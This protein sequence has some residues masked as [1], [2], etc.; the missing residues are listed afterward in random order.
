MKKLLAVLA[1]F[2]LPACSINPPPAY[3]C[4]N[5]P[6][7]SGLVEVEEPMLAQYIVVLKPA[8][9]ALAAADLQSFAT[10][11]GGTNVQSLQRTINGFSAN[12]SEANLQAALSNPRV[13]YI[14][15]VGEKHI[16]AAEW[17]LDRIDQ[18]DL[19]LDGSYS[20]GAT[21]QGVN[22]AIVDTGVTDVPEFEGRLVLDDC[23]SAYGS[24]DDGHG[25]GTHVAGTVG[26][27]TY[28][29]AKKVK[30]WRAR[31]L[32]AQGSGSDAA[33]IGGIEWVTNKALEKGGRWV[34]NM[35][36]GGSAS[37]ALDAAVC[38]AIAA[39]V[40][41]AVAAGNETRDSRYSSPAR[42]LQAITAGASDR[43]DTVA[44]F[45]NYG[46]GVDVH[47]PGVDVRSTSPG[48]GTAVY[49]GTSMASPHVAGAAALCLD[50]DPGL[51]PAGV[52][53]C[54]VNNATPD[55]LGSLH[56]DTPNRLLYVRVP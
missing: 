37:P 2:A 27:K 55:K 28:G 30:L 32:N 48:G 56:S 29:V 43:N 35:S 20:P 47:A 44:Y 9:Q 11:L 13:Q 26:S 23:F 4:S 52:E 5:P 31:V 41:N 3:D 42:V 1:L 46:P 54:V 24:C 33:V 19:P 14:Q 16:N 51:S 18:R 10:A 40:T 36:L 6:A 34:L 53:A 12:F 39:G 7:L 25:H 21:G 8:P 49:S 50:R 38:S 45:S 22:V 17:G 15:E